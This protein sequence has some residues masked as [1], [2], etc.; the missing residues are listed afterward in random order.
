[1]VLRVSMIS[2]IL[3]GQ[4]PASREERAWLDF[5]RQSVSADND[6]LLNSDWL[7]YTSGLLP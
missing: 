7:A 5:S 1:M 3:C 6:W 4:G 2:V